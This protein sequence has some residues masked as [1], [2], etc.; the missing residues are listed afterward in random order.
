MG[1]GV[2]GLGFGDGGWGPTPNPQSPIP[3]PQ[4]PSKNFT[5]II[6]LKKYYNYFIKKNILINKGL[7]KSKIP[8][9]IILQLIN[10]LPLI[11]NN[12]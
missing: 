11:N 4:S 8:I 5:T 1:M 6:Y 7:D 9:F 2:G 10:K 3:N 12:I